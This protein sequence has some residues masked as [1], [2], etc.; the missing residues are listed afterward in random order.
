MNKTQKT[1]F[2]AELNINGKKK[3]AS[4][5]SAFTTHI[6]EWM[7]GDHY[8]GKISVIKIYDTSGTLK[9][10]ASPPNE[11][12]RSIDYTNY[13]ADIYASWTIT[14][15]ESFTIDKVEIYVED[16]AKTFQVLVST[17]TGLN[18]N[19]SAN[20]THKFEFHLY[21]DGD[22]VG[23]RHLIYTSRQLA[24][25]EER[26]YT[27]YNARLLDENGNPIKE[28]TKK[29][30]ERIE[31]YETDTEIGAMHIIEFIDDST[32]EYTVAQL[33]FETQDDYVYLYGDITPLTKSA[34]D[35][36]IY[37]QKVINVV[38]K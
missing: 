5:N 20:S 19:V 6:C 11:L 1:S 32:D 2:R 24:G 35:K 34:E 10:E 18:Y 8:L 4:V 31:S 27:I 7:R 14:F 33:E 28:V 29:H 9:K 23:V 3:H 38:P 25:E 26:Y 16:S 12:S 13:V 15:D 22:E 17:F 36:V 21:E 37:R 30:D